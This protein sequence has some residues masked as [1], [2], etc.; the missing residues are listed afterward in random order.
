MTTN[1]YLTPI[2]EA[3]LARVTECATTGVLKA[4]AFDIRIEAFP[5]DDGEQMFSIDVYT[6]ATIVQPTDRRQKPYTEAKRTSF[7]F[8]ADGTPD[9]P[10]FTQT[11]T[12]RYR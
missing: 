6:D 1:M 7:F 11:S 10:D 12:S 3:V 2:P 9:G 4:G 8:R 5:G